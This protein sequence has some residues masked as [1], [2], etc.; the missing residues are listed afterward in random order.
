MPTEE[1]KLED[2][3]FDKNTESSENPKKN[4]IHHSGNLYSKSA[5]NFG[6]FENPED[7][8]VEA[9]NKWGEKIP[10]LQYAIIEK[11]NLLYFENNW[12][13]N[14]KQDDIESIEIEFWFN[15]TSKGDKSDNLQVLFL[16]SQEKIMV[17][18]KKSR[19]FVKVNGKS[20]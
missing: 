15:C 20:I 10:S 7:S 5:I 3:A 18:L 12:V 19:I 1:K 4:K 6:H 14:Q 13:D 17:G 16:S 2:W 9:E 11:D 8:P